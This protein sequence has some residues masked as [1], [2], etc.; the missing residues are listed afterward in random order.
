[1]RKR[2]PTKTVTY[3]PY[4][5]ALEIDLMAENR[6]LRRIISEIAQLYSVT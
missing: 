4:Y 6:E 3:K 2:K 1:M 5:S